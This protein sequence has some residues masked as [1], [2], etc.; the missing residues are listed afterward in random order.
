MTFNKLEVL[1][2]FLVNNHQLE[3]I[4]FLQHQISTNGPKRLILIECHFFF[5][6][7]FEISHRYLPGSLRCEFKETSSKLLALS[8]RGYLNWGVA[9]I[10]QTGVWGGG[11]TLFQSEGTH[12]TVMSFSSPDVGCF[13]KKAYKRGGGVTG[14][15]EPPSLYPC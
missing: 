3:S 2:L 5:D 7:S 4:C 14:T 9:K 13:L 15:L 6:K 11:F 12:Q 8:C 10:F 1:V